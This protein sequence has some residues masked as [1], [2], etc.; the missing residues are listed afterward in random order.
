M[1]LCNKLLKSTAFCLLDIMP[2]HIDL[3]SFLSSPFILNYYYIWSVASYNNYYVVFGCNQHRLYLQA[4]LRLFLIIIVLQRKSLKKIYYYDY[5]TI[6]STQFSMNK[7]Y[8]TSKTNKRFGVH[9][10]I[11]KNLILLISNCAKNTTF[12]YE[13]RRVERFVF[14]MH[15]WDY[16]SLSL[17]SGR[18][19]D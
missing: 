12:D 19:C 18:E 6:P 11:A 14:F 7:S 13:Q 5:Y 8:M 4:P 1:F 10:K 2:M 9:F 3:L 15:H 16:K 17:V